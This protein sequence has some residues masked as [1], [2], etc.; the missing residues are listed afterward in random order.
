MKND[1]GILFFFFFQKKLNFEQ[2]KVTY[3]MIFICVF[4][5]RTKR[6]A[7][8]MGKGFTVILMSLDLRTL[9]ESAFSSSHIFDFSSTW[10]P[11]KR[12]IQKLRYGELIRKR[13]PRNQYTLYFFVIFD[14]Q[15]PNPKISK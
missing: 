11:G 10:I 9:I 1:V 8:I 12:A 5:L 7:S 4:Y 2:N 13:G 6:H 15:L 3:K 14:F